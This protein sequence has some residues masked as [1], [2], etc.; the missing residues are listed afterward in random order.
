M[1]MK[2]FSILVLL[3]TLSACEKHSAMRSYEEVVIE[4]S[5]VKAKAESQLPYVWTKPADWTEES[6]N[7]LRLATFK[8]TAEPAAMDCSIVF[9]PNWR[10]NVEENL[11]RWLGQLQIT[12]PSGISVVEY[13]KK[14]GAVQT[15]NSLNG[16]LAFELYDFT[17]VQKSSAPAT[18]SMIAATLITP[19]G[20]FFIKMTGTKEKVEANTKSFLNLVQSVHP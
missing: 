14:E 3:C 15:L 8:S 6:G 9:F 5:L 16:N 12:P 17:Q 10:G 2:F 1:N 19:D 13:F 20:A 11:N 4:S 18:P 7:A